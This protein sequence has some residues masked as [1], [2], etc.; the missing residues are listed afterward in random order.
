MKWFLVN[1][2][3][4]QKPQ[5]SRK[6]NFDS[7]HKNVKRNKRKQHRDFPI[8]LLCD[9]ILVSSIDQRAE[10][11]Y[12][13]FTSNEAA[14]F[15]LTHLMLSLLSS[16]WGD[17]DVYAHPFWLASHRDWRCTIRREPCGSAPATGGFVV[18]RMEAS[19]LISNAMMPRHRT[20]ASHE[21]Q[22]FLKQ[23]ARSGGM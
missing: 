12:D 18:A 11:F 15:Q 20:T 5:C 9:E 2:V 6:G 21:N 7:T 23:T 16:L 17:W 1:H 3:E 8:H 10:L 19:T 13:P 4:S 22:F 14:I